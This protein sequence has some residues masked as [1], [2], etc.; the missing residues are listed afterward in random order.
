MLKVIHGPTY[1]Y[2]KEILESPTTVIIQD[3]CYNEKNQIFPLQELLDNSA[4]V[5]ADHTLVFDHELQQ[6]EFSQ[7]QCMYLPALLAREAREFIE[8][9]TSPHWQIKTHA[10]NFMINKKQV[11]RFLCMK[12]VEYFNL[13]DFSYTWSGI[14]DS[15]D[16]EKIIAE[17]SRVSDLPENLYNEIL[18]PI[19]TINQNFSRL[20]GLEIEVDYK[21][22]SGIS[23]YGDNWQVWNVV[24]KKMFETSA[25][26]LIT[27]SVSYSKSIC[28]S[29]KTLFS[30]LGLSFPI[31]VGGYK[32]AEEW[33]RSGF[34]TF[35][36]IIN[37]D[38]QHYDTLVER[39]YYAFKN[40]LEVLTNK[41]K[42]SALR[43]LH[44][45]RLLNNRELILNNQLTK[46]NNS[47][48]S[49]W[50][51]ELQNAIMPSIITHFRF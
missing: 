1:Q 6:D 4:C 25:I 39:C 47:Q 32:Q 12:L 29:E 35:D 22:L 11:N 33:K 51:Q 45:G 46:F 36:D 7:Y 17:R 16:M 43:E 41:E 49:S 26:S 30:I 38:Y 42:I 14:G 31:W 21:N 48:V 2:Q 18:S 37:H 44:K 10:F 24:V 27:E 34:D 23:N 19:K 50:P 20:N 5:P 15:F 3:H 13:K 8:H 28:F 40:N 9:S